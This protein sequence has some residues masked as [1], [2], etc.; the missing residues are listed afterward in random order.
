MLRLGRLR[1]RTRRLD[2]RRAAGKRQ[3]GDVAG[4]LDR[5]AK[6]ALVTRTDAGHAPGQ[7]LAAF[8]DKLRENV[9]ALVVDEIHLL[10]TEL[11]D[12]LFAEILALAAARATRPAGS[13]FATTSSRASFATA[14]A[15]MS[16]LATF[17]GSG[18]GN[19]RSLFLFL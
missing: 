1:D 13:R 8:L 10:D 9:G 5:D 2:A 14:T 19:A 12:F 17:A 6:P 15:G 16:S 11:A 3:Q 7:N 4:A 18:R